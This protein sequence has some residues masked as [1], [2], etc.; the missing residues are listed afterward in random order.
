MQDSSIDTV[1]IASVSYNL[2]AFYATHWA[3][4][5]AEHYYLEAVGGCSL[6]MSPRVVMF[7]VFK[8]LAKR[9]CF[10]SL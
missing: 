1:E 4:S 8:V 10:W 3:L 9:F 7:V 5:D 6:L 2:A